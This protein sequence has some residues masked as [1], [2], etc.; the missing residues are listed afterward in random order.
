MCET[1]VVLTGFTVTFQFQPNVIFAVF[2]KLIV[3]VFLV[4]PQMMDEILI[5]TSTIYMKDF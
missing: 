4:K 2:P 3:S 5:M 1:S